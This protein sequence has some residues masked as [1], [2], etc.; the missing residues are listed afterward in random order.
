MINIK[1]KQIV[2]IVLIVV[3][4]LISA[5]AVWQKDNIKAF[6][7]GLTNDENTLAEKREENDK[8]I[9]DT[10]EKYPELTVRD[11]T[12]EEKEALAQGKITQEEVLLL[13]Q[14]KKTLEE[15]LSDNPPEEPTV[16]EPVKEEPKEEIPVKPIEPQP[17]VVTPP[18]E[19]KPETDTPPAVTEPEPQ[20]PSVNAEIESLVGQMYILKAE[21]T[22]ALKDL[23]STTLKD[24]AALPKE[25]KTAQV[26]TDMMNKVLDTVAKM[27]K[28]CDTRVEEILKKLE[29]LLKESS[30][31]ISLVEA[32]RSA[33]KNEK[34]ITKAEYINTYF[35]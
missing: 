25:E 5:V 21:F 16:D 8:I 28:D 12:A 4:V 35:K 19:E 2:L 9:T 24:Y 22:A 13:I 20:A 18:V 34:T 27:E 6:Y 26:K 3:I 14:G 33:Y 32:I 11:L 15:L 23:E 7:M 30:Q 31:D 29:A 1:R 17:P 10:L